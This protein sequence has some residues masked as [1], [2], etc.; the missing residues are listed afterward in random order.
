[1]IF[2]VC[3]SVV[4]YAHFRHMEDFFLSFIPQMV[5][6]CLLFLWMVVMMFMKWILYVPEIGTAS[7]R[8]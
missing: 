4:N 2:G 3:M 7:Y 1:M 5:F 8:L 6:L